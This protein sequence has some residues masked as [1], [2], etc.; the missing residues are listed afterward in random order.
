M[1]GTQ[2]HETGPETQ[3]LISAV[4]GATTRWSD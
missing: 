3:N 1:M 2:T 4:E